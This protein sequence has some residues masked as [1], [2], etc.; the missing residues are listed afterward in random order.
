MF[1]TAVDPRVVHDVVVVGAGLTGSWVAKELC[2]AGL[3]VALLDGGP[4]IP[5]P[6]SASAQGWTEERRRRAAQR[7]PVQSQS[8]AYW[9][10]NP[11]LFVDD[12][13]HPYHF[14]GVAPYYW[15]RGRQVGGRSLIWDGRA[16]R[17]TEDE[18]HVADGFSPRWPVTSAELEPFYQRVER[19]FGVAEQP[20]PGAGSLTSIERRFKQTIETRWPDRRVTP[21][22][23]VRPEG[24]P[25][26]SAATEWPAHTMLHGVLRDA[27]RTGCLAAR[28]DAIV[29]RLL[30]DN[31]R[32]RVLGARCVDRVDYSSLDVRGR[33]V[34]LCASA[35]ESVRILLNSRSEKHP[36]GLGNSSGTL[37]AFLLDR[38][39]TLSRGFVP[40]TQSSQDSCVASRHG[41]L[42]P[43]F[44]NVG[45]KSSEYLRGFGL[46]VEIGAR[47]WAATDHPM[48][49]MLATL[50]VLPREW[51]RIELDEP[52]DNWG[53]PM[54]RIAFSLS[55]N[56]LKMQADADGA[57]RE[58]AAEL[59]WPLEQQQRLSPGTVGPAL[60][61]ARMG[62]DP[63][64]AV[65]SPFNQSWD[66]KN[67]F[68]L[69]GSAF[70]SA[71]WQDPA[72]TLMALAVR[73]SQYIHREA[74]REF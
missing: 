73:G 31:R 23:G 53:V 56:E 47:R 52:T 44:R 42:V 45:R 1:S 59:S 36:D 41:V 35:I 24:S 10:L 2:E 66:V 62:P 15:I 74:I 55:E 32:N 51:N 4:I 14:S 46:S 13:E 67:L 64:T 29:S 50:E 39:A 26:S 18:L 48:W 33:A 17:Y 20:D 63:A 69:D 27:E 6:Q 70:V 12:L 21:C 58:I 5:D 61:G 3:T 28:P 9:N 65:V 57:V 19:Y 60:G 40:V 37:G 72:L 11:S 43:R 68:V 16:Q 49:Q 71:G 8:P 38:A 34:V 30:V 22:P 7:Q 25:E 54:P